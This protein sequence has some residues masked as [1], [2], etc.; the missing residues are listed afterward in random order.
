MDISKI[1]ALPDPLRN[2]DAATVFFVLHEV[3]FEGQDRVIGLMRS[4]RKLF[5]VVPLI[6]FEACLPGPGEMRRKPGMAV[7]YLLQHE[8]T[9]QR[10]AGR[11]TWKELFA[12]AGFAS[13]DERYLKFARTSIFIIV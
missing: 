11:E 6:V 12:A 2:I 1:E 4:F 9:R 5:P 10:L 3:L 8:L 13:I 7:Q